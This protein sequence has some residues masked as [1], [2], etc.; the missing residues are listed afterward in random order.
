MPLLRLGYKKTVAFILE[1]LFH[2][3]APRE[4]SYLVVSCTMERP[5]WQGKDVSRQKPN[6]DLKPVNSQWVSLEMGPLPV[7]L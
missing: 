3:F 4:A 5:T 7:E 1:S 2:S 6:K